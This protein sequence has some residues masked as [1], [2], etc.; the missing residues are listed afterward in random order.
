MSELRQE[1]EEVVLEGNFECYIEAKDFGSFEVTGTYLI[2][3]GCISYVAYFGNNKLH[4]A[5]G[6]HDINLTGFEYLDE[7]SQRELMFKIDDAI[8]YE[9]SDL[10]K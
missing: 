1:V 5:G 4:N 3:E 9:L 2:A 7:M 6:D 10:M 8:Q